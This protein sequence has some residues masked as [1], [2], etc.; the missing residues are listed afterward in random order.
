MFQ[1]MKSKKGFTLA[2]LLIVVAIIAI[3][4]AIAVPLFVGAMNDA[5]E[6][7]GKGNCRAVKGL[8]VAYI[9]GHADEMGLNNSSTAAAGW[10]AGAKVD[11]N[12][13]VGTIQVVK[14]DEFSK[15]NS[16]YQISASGSF[17]GSVEGTVTSSSSTATVKVDGTVGWYKRNSDGSFFVLVF[18]S[19]VSEIEVPD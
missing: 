4:A 7:V 5:Q 15:L 1:K 2:E 17:D 18:I 11:A 12:G 19:D 8:A 13:D 9:L 10:Y 3:L 16:S 6:E 14:A